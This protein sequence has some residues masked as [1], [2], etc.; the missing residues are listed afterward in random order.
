MGCQARPWVSRRY[1]RK[2]E[3]ESVDQDSISQRG[4]STGRDLILAGALLSITL[5]PLVFAAVDQFAA[6]LRA[7]PRLIARLERS[8]SLLATLPTGADEGGLRGHAVI[9]GY[10]RVGGTIGEA[11]KGQGQDRKDRGR[12]RV[13]DR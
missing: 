9:V 6:W 13:P 8:D 7:Q 10:G 12:R 4:A 1:T 3:R 2:P 11:L 5:N